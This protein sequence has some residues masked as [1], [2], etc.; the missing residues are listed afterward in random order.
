MWRNV[1]YTYWSV[2]NTRRRMT[3]YIAFLDFSIASACT[4]SLIQRSIA[5]LDYSLMQKGLWLKSWIIQ[6][7]GLNKSLKH[8]MFKEVGCLWKQKRLSLSS[9]IW[10]IIYKTA[11]E[12]SKTFFLMQQNRFS[13]WKEFMHLL[14]C[15]PITL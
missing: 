11:D 15:L 10:N 13:F 12:N 2:T 3:T 14:V 5:A 8:K 9:Y 4:C 6:S 1:Y 7:H